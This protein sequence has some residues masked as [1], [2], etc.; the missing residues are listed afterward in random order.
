MPI[1]SFRSSPRASAFRLFLCLLFA[2]RLG[3]GETPPGAD[4]AVLLK[5]AQAGQAESMYQLALAYGHGRG[6][7]R[8]LEQAAHWLR[9]AAAQ[10]RPEALRKLDVFDFYPGM[11]RPE[12][13]KKITTK[14]GLA[15]LTV[16][17]ERGE[18]EAEFALGLHRE[19]ADKAV[20]AA[21]LAKAAAQRHRSAMSWLSLI[22][23]NGDGVPRDRGQ[24]HAWHAQAALL[25]DRG[26]MIKLGENYLWGYQGNKDAALAKF[27]YL[28]AAAGA[29]A[30]DTNAQIALSGLSAL[31]GAPASAERALGL[32]RQAAKLAALPGA[33]PVAP[34]AV[35]AVPPPAPPKPAPVA[36][37]RVLTLEEHREAAAGGNVE[38]MY[39]LG[40][41]DL[42]RRQI[43]S[44]Q[45]TGPYYNDPQRNATDFR[46]I[47]SAARAG[48][49]G[50]QFLAATHWL[51]AETDAGKKAWLEKA[52]AQG[53]ATAKERLAANEKAAADKLSAEA[54]EAKAAAEDEKL[55][56]AADA[57]AAFRA[58]RRRIGRMARA[59]TDNFLAQQQGQPVAG[60]TP[61]MGQMDGDMVK[62]AD[63]LMGAGHLAGAALIYGWCS[64]THP[65]LAYLALLLRR[66]LTTLH[67]D[68]ALKEGAQGIESPA[69]WAKAQELLRTKLTPALRTEV[70]GTATRLF[71]GP[72]WVVA[73]GV[74]FQKG[75]YGFPQD[76][77]QAVRLYQ[78]AADAGSPVALYNLATCY[79][80]GFGV[81]RDQLAAYDLM[82]KAVALGYKE[83]EK[84]I[85]TAEQNP[86]FARMLAAREIQQSAP[87]KPA[88]RADT[89]MLIAMVNDTG[90][91]T[92][93][94]GPPPPETKQRASG[95][96]AERTGGTTQP[97]PQAPAGYTG[98]PYEDAALANRRRASEAERA[99]A[100][101]PTAPDGLVPELTPGTYAA[102]LRIKQ[103]QPGVLTEGDAQELKQAILQG[104]GQID[105]A[106]RDLLA[107][108]TQSQFRKIT[109]RSAGAKPDEPPMVL[110]PVAGRTKKVL[111][112]LLQGK[113]DFEVEWNRGAEGFGAL[114]NYL[115][116]SPEAEGEVLQYV[117]GKF[118]NEWERSN[119]ANGYKPLRDLIGRQYG[120]SNAPG[121]DLNGGRDLIYR[122]MNQ[123]DRNSKDQ[124]PDFLYNWVR[125]G[126]S[127]K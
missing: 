49:P 35:T 5:A 7:D 83:A 89:E 93:P 101:P 121:N 72:D 34:V 46:R 6:V 86:V 79:W 85:T 29:P 28:Q 18:P 33:Q 115:K 88:D 116:V 48:H 41:A 16:A 108:M 70:E 123:I 39:Q 47:M 97:R 122:A 14:E 2:L 99:K 103:R 92:E 23:E 59:I 63:Q 1:P 100:P 87:I 68:L 119:Q 44:N 84:G 76:Y 50:A 22:Y 3:A 120:Y 56:S 17:A 9:L 104:D 90:S 77:G 80:S 111:R 91:G 118:A 52:A 66:E 95:T 13:L 82:K 78:K 113:P 127:A 42:E 40:L 94:D 55:A 32:V 96:E 31:P 65:R 62:W 106:E 102:L 110:Y 24:S 60:P 126:G 51:S 105:D 64:D 8:D 54:A 21:W 19:I 71:T 45:H 43:E 20:K 125:P 107:E 11:A 12:A 27:W 109:A 112:E 114:C 58:L 61:Q 26:A 117:A 10:G 38:S 124:I 15:E 73:Y 53:H 67:P 98:N 57:E 25:G 69:G 36:A 30:G 37:P 74:N 81:S 4:V 75:R